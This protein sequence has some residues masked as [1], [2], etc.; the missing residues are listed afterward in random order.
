MPGECAEVYC[1]C[2][3][4][5]PIV[6]DLQFIIEKW[7]TGIRSRDVL[8]TCDLKTNTFTGI[9][10]VTKI[11]QEVVI[12]CLD[13]FDMTNRS[14]YNLARSSLSLPSLYSGE[15]DEMTP[16]TH[17]YS[18]APGPNPYKDPLQVFA[19][20]TT[21]H[22]GGVPPKMYCSSNTTLWKAIDTL[23]PFSNY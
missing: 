11:R 19:F 23:I 7:P 1:W 3:V 16:K 14:L 12:T 17:Y 4:S 13:L 22:R 18:L 21:T 15:E 8:L 9:F 2:V 6:S 20:G 5:A 10:Q